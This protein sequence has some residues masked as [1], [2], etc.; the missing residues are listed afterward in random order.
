MDFCLEPSTVIMLYI[1]TLKAKHAISANPSPRFH[2]LPYR[3]GE[4][5]GL[6]SPREYEFLLHY[7]REARATLS[8]QDHNQITEESQFPLLVSAFGCSDLT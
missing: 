3:K 7:T 8:P 2:M 5:W 6:H 4:T 1:I